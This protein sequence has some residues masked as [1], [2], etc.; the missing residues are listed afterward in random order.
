MMVI[1][2]CLAKTF[3]FIRSTHVAFSETLFGAAWQLCVPKK[4]KEGKL[5]GVSSSGPKNDN[6]VKIVQPLVEQVTKW[7]IGKLDFS[8]RLKHICRL[9]STS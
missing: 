9:E 4:N 2:D 7:S 3:T 1:Y 5:R 8:L 6:D